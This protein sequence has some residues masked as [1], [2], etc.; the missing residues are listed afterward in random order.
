MR[1]LDAYRAEWLAQR[2]DAWAATHVRGEQSR[3]LLERR[4]GCFDDLADDLAAIVRL[5]SSAGAAEIARAPEMVHALEP[6][7]TCADP[8]NLE[9]RSPP[10]STSEGRAAENDLRALEALQLAGRRDEALARGTELVAEA[11]RLGDPALLARATFHLG[12]AQANV[13][14]HADAEATLRRAV[15]QAASAR[16]HVLVAK[17]WLRLFDIVGHELGR[18][19]EAMAF[20][21]AVRAA[22]AQ[23]GDDPRQL[24]ELASALGYVANA[25]GRFR[26]ARTYFTEARDR[27]IAARGP[28]HPNVGMVEN[29]LGGVMLSLGELDEATQH[30]ER[31]I[32]IMEAAMGPTNPVVGKTLFN[33][34]SIAGRRK[35]W[36][37]AERYLRRSI[38]VDEQLLGPDHPELG[39]SRIFLARAL[40]NQARHAEAATE[41]ATA[42][43]ALEKALPPTHV[44]RIM[45][46]V[47]DAQLAEAAGKFDEAERL[48]AKGLA[49]IR[50]AVPATHPQ[51]AFVLAVLACRAGLARRA[52]T[53]ALALYDEALNLYVK[54]DGRSVTAEVETLREIADTALAARA[55]A[56]ALHWFD[57]LPE[58]GRQLAPVREQLERAR[59]QRKRK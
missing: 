5:L 58:A 2:V 53:D 42:R 43:Q 35:D 31:S 37:T 3:V 49:A 6:I 34:S 30:L 18:A 13:G 7:A 22:V 15:Q 41:L 9:T 1:V 10:P 46:D 47:H 26:E 12:S 16:D 25:R 57:R 8:H 36:A 52:P 32:A 28:A 51:L 48:G 27:H 56:R 39:K 4:L 14:K 23:A 54:G 20:E 45:L 50:T 33:L 11:E 40:R 29:N 44:Q 38:K 55:P 24:A 19:D 59:G 21:S 17:V